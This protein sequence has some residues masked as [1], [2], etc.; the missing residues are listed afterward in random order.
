MTSG[1]MEVTR[2]GPQQQ[3]AMCPRPWGVQ[4]LTSGEADTVQPA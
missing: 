2:S 4:R 1:D 3:P